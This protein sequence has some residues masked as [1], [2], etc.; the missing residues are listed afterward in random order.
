MKGYTYICPN[1]ECR[2]I[3]ELDSNDNL[4]TGHC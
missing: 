1:N 4:I 2:E 3:W